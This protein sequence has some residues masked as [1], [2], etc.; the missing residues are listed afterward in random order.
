[1]AAPAR[2]DVADM[3]TTAATT[4]ARPR[5]LIE[6]PPDQ[7]EL[8]LTHCRKSGAMVQGGPERESPFDN[9]LHR[10][11]ICATARWVQSLDLPVFVGASR[12][13]GVRA[14]DCRRV[15]AARIDRI[16]TMTVYPAG[17]STSE[18]VGGLFLRTIGREA[19]IPGRMS[20]QNSR[21]APG[22]FT[23]GR[24]RPILPAH[25]HRR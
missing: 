14:I 15:P 10:L 8:R 6:L 25:D 9:E 18:W 1:M 5:R 7:P 19:S 23:A 24:F 16:S 12:A 11:A 21:H 20:G 4:A 17:F 3:K 2:I 13:D 22:S